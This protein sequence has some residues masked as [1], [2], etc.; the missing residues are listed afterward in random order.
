MLTLV[1]PSYFSDCEIEESLLIR[2]LYHLERETLDVVIRYAADDVA[3]AVAA[4]KLG[5]P[6]TASPADFRHFRFEGLQNLESG[7]GSRGPKT[8]WPAYERLLLAKPQVL[9]GVHHTSMG[10][11]FQ[12]SFFLGR[13]G[14]HR[15]AYTHVLVEVRRAVATETSPQKWVYHDCMTN[16]VVCFH[17]PFPGIDS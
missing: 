13:F 12:M 7:N 6:L 8:E 3:E 2:F 16:E 14:V 17:N 10:G 4:Q 9:T 11:Q 1:P 15:F 5:K